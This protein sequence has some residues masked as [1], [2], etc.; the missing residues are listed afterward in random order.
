[1]VILTENGTSTGLKKILD[2]IGVSADFA[3]TNDTIGK[4]DHPTL[5]V[6]SRKD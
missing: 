1:M 2:E 5:F 6:G 4:K 3:E